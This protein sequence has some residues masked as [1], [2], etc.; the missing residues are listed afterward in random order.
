MRTFRSASLEAR[1]YPPSGARES[2][3]AERRAAPR[4]GSIAER[5][6]IARAEP[7]AASPPRRE[8]GDDDEHGEH[9]RHAA[10]RSA[11]VDARA[12]EGHDHVPRA[13]QPKPPIEISI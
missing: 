10:A 5:P 6:R 9:A 1:P 12:P 7:R 4:R 3:L 11:G 2:T 8:R 13:R